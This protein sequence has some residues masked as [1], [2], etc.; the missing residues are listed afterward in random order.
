MNPIIAESIIVPVI[1]GLVEVA[2]LT[3]LPSRF[4][5]L[6][7]VILGVVIHVALLATAGVPTAA[8]FGL[9][10]GL[11]AAGLYSGIKASVVAKPEE[12]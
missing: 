3:G 11:T 9:V 10:S 1:I 6:T 4:A 8:F 12:E 7:S 2:K 5:P